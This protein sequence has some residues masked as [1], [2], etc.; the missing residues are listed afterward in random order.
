MH[1]RGA[2]PGIRFNDY[3]FSEPT[4]L[5]DWTP[6]PCAGLLAILAEDSSWAPKPFQPLCFVEFGNNAPPVVVLDDLPH[7]LAAESRA[8][9]VATLAVPFSTTSQRFAI[10]GDLIR[11]YNPAYQANSARASRRDL[12]REVEELDRTNQKR[13]AQLPPLLQ[14]DKPASPRRRIGFIG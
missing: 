8:L 13:A 2:A 1:Q 7:V 4:R 9:Y 12:V 5:L 11:A 6:S 10:C 14:Q 3:I